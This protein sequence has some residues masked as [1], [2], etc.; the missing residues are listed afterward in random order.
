M[1]PLQ[2]ASAMF[3]RYWR[4]WA[5][6]RVLWLVPVLIQS[7]VRSR[8]SSRTCSSVTGWTTIKFPQLE[9]GSFE[10]TE[11]SGL[12]IIKLCNR[13][14]AFSISHL[15]SIGPSRG[16]HKTPNRLQRMPNAHSI[17]ARL[18]EWTKLKI[19]S[20]VLCG[21]VLN[22]VIMHGHAEYAES[23]HK[24]YGRWRPPFTNLVARSEAFQ[25]IESWLLAEKANEM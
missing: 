13:K 15:L 18:E 1:P 23:P 8:Y 16:R 11:L 7:L 17:L 12:S 3:C 5:P 24:K 10:H 9:R 21:A 4:D 14:T 20:M 22:G 19:S 2:R 25:H 6:D